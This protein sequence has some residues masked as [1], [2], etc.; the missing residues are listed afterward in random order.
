M[1]MIICAI[2]FYALL[3]T[4]CSQKK[5]DVQETVS[6][7]K[8]L[9]G[10]WLM[11][12]DDGIITEQWKP[13]NDSLME[14]SSDFIK[15]DSVIPF[16]ILRLFRKSN[17]F[18]YEAI[19]AGQNDEQPVEFLLTSF[20]DTGFVAENPQHDFPKRIVYKL[21]STGEI[22]AYVDDGSD[23]GKR[24]DFIYKQK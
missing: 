3:L 13:V 21:K 24:L 15:G 17:T 10:N 22:H 14:G 12:T 8:W 6:R 9:T 2:M 16:E 18:Y 11:K 1:K 7:F 20:S 23:T 5:K 19:A 4:G